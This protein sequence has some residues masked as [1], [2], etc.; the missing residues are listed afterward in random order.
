MVERFFNEDLTAST[1]SIDAIMGDVR[2]LGEFHAKV[3]N[4]QQGAERYDLV[5]CRQGNGAAR[6]E[7]TFTECLDFPLTRPSDFRNPKTQ[8]PVFLPILLRK[9]YD[10]L[11]EQRSKN[12]DM[13]IL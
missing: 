3:S 9:A 1:S 12:Q 13:P 6:K 5:K 7:L 4:I 2:N 11:G 8:K 10:R